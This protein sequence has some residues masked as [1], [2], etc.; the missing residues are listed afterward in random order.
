MPYI[1]V[2]NNI[3]AYYMANHITFDAKNIFKD[4]EV[5]CVSIRKTNSI[6]SFT[7]AFVY[8]TATINTSLSYLLKGEE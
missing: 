3:I 8:Y 4:V 5:I 2:A 7:S 1:T 6:R